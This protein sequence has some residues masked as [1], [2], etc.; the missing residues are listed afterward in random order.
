MSS[1]YAVLVPYVYCTWY[2]NPLPSL[3][4]PFLQVLFGCCGF[5]FISMFLSEPLISGYTTGSALLVFTSQVSHI[6]GIKIKTTAVFTSFPDVLKLPLVSY[7]FMYFTIIMWSPTTDMERCVPSDLSL[8]WLCQYS[9]FCN[10][11]HH[12]YRDDHFQS[13]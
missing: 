7:V 9:C 3:S 13:Y 1:W 12:H 10:I 11:S 4:L 6:F 8:A 5:G 2:V